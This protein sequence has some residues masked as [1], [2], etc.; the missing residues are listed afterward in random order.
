MLARRLLLFAAVLLLLA[1]LAAGLAPRRPL[2]DAPPSA[3]PAAADAP[4]TSSGRSP[5]TGR[6]Q[7]DLG[8]RR[9]PDPARGRRRHARQRPARAAW[10]GSTAIEP[11]TPARFEV[12]AERPGVY[13]IRLVEADRRIGRLE[14]TA[15]APARGLGVVAGD[16]PPGALAPRARDGLRLP[17]L[18]GDHLAGA[19]AGGAA[20]GGRRRRRVGHGAAHASAGAGRLSAGRAARPT[21]PRAA[22]SPPRRSV[23][24]AGRSVGSERRSAGGTSRSVTGRSSPTSRNARSRRRGVGQPQ[25]QPGDDRVAER[26][27]VGQRAHPVRARTPRATTSP[28][29]GLAN[30]SSPLGASSSSPSAGSALPPRPVHTQPSMPSSRGTTALGPSRRRTGKRPVSA[31]ARAGP[32]VDRRERERARRQERAAR[33]GS[34]ACSTSVPDARE[35]HG[36]LAPP[37]RSSRRPRGSSSRTTRRRDGAAPARGVGCTGA[38][39]SLVAGTCSLVRITLQLEA[40]GSRKYGG[41]R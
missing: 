34:A 30:R 3:L 16:E 23:G 39:C 31:P 25:Q 18:G 5:P 11:L 2:P 28:A 7:S 21:S 12:L 20:L 15:V 6:D 32:G 40:T 35:G 37:P 36:V 10:T 26:R 24:S 17:A 33:A 1:T 13:P 29:S 19:A 22:S 14:I 9:R 41:L 8:A 38:G 4:R 27:A